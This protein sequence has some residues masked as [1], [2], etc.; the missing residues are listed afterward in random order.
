MPIELRSIRALTRPRRRQLPPELT[1]GI[2][3]RAFRGDPGLYER[4]LATLREPI[5]SAEIVLRG[6]AVMGRSYREHQRFDANGPGTSDLD[7]VL[8]GRDA[9]KLWTPESFYFPGVNT[10]PLSDQTPWVA[11][12][13]EPARRAAQA[14]V[15]RP[16]NIQAMARWFLEARAILQGQRHVTLTEP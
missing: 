12:S 14:M 2:V 6:S 13:L 15:G 8:V 11:P 5:G 3:R 4:F 10:H 16:V 7:L 1:D 9:F